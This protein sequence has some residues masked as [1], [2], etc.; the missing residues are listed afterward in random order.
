MPLPDLRKLVGFPGYCITTMTVEPRRCWHSV[1]LE[2][3]RLRGLHAGIVPL[4]MPCAHYFF[5]HNF[6]K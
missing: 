3:R 4:P 2:I 1:I 6:R 5:G